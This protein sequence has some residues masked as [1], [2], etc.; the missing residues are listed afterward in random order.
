[1]SMEMEFDQEYS[2]TDCV[3]ATNVF[4]TDVP[5]EKKCFIDMDLPRN[6]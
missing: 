2:L 4:V 6:V 5:R 3:N 1:M